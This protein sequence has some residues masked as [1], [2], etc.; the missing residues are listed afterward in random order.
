MNYEIYDSNGLIICQECGD[1][2]KRITPLH[3][4]KHGMSLQEYNEKYNYPPIVKLKD[5]NPIDEGN[6]KELMREE[7]NEEAEQYNEFGNLPRQKLQVIYLLKDHLKEIE[8]D[9]IVQ[10]Y[11]DV[12]KQFLEHIFVTDIAD[13]KSKICFFFPDVFWRNEET[14]MHP[15]KYNILEQHGWRVF[16]IN[17]TNVVEGIKRVLDNIKN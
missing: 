7:I 4:R 17:G 6:K 12:G 13:P 15:D 10:L 8:S 5:E 16:V 11:G 9:Y 14:V 2:L 3:L 1:S